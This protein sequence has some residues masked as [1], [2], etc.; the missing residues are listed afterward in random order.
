[1]LPKTEATGDGEG[2]KK[3]KRRP[4]E[5]TGERCADCP[6][7]ALALLTHHTCLILSKQ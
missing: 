3:A 5:K 6:C 7:L 1:M 2:K 4:K